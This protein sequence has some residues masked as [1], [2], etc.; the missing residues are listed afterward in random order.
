MS[1]SSQ[2]YDDKS[3]NKSCDMGSLVCMECCYS[4]SVAHGVTAASVLS[5]YMSGIHTT[6]INNIEYIIKYEIYF[7]FHRCQ[8]V[9][10]YYHFLSSID[11][12]LTSRFP[13]FNLW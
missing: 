8:P 12:R 13:N 10:K 4:E 2:F 6:S 11:K 7:A 3:S 9:L 5:S 1:G